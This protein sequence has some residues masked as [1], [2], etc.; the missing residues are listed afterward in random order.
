M[1]FYMLPANNIKLLGL[2]IKLTDTMLEFTKLENEGIQSCDI[3]VTG[4]FCSTPKFSW[5]LIHLGKKVQVVPYFERHIGKTST[6]S[7]FIG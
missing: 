1:L 5:N 4:I 6:F 7:T 2:K 3:G